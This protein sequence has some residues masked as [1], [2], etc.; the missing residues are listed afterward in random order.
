MWERRVGQWLFKDIICRWGGL[1]KIV[2]DNGAPFKKAIMWLEEKYGIKEMTISPYNSKAN[3]VIEQPYWD[4]YQILYKTTN[5]NVRKWYANCITIRKGTECSPYFMITGTC[6]ILPLDIQEATWPVTYSGKMM[7]TKNF[8]GLRAIALAKDK[9]I[10]LRTN[11]EKLAQAAK[12]E[13][14]NT[15]KIKNWDFKLENLVLVRNMAI[16]V[17]ANQKI[18]QIYLGPMV[19]IARGKGGAYI[20]AEMDRLVWQNKVAAFRIIPY[21]ARKSILL[22]RLVT[23]ALDVSDEIF[24]ELKESEEKHWM[25]EDKWSDDEKDLSMP[26]NILQGTDKFSPVKNSSRYNLTKYYSMRLCD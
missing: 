11:K 15:V 2:T 21:L 24:N 17:S 20:L 26:K 22:S 7:S 25:L 6:L 16:E 13:Q 19:V 5:D 8:L 3:G 12:I 1:V 18:K 23:E 10:H 14:E 4:I 9:A